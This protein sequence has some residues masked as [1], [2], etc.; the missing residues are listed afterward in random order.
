VFADPDTLFLLSM[1][2]PLACGDLAVVL[3]RLRE[4]WPPPRLIELLASP[5][6]AAAR[7]AATCLGLT[8]SIEHCHHLV[9]LLGHGD[10]EVA[11]AA[12]DALWSIW[13]QAGSD[14]ACAELQAAVE[15]LQD[16]DLAA[17]LSRLD[18]LVASEGSF[19]E[20]RH[21]RA[22][23]LHSLERYEEAAAAYQ[24]ALA[25]NPHHFAAVAGLGHI[26]AER[27]DYA[28]ALRYY[29]RALHIHP[30]LREI[31]ATVPRLEAALRRIVA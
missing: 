28:G 22:L 2:P 6:P 1:D 20:A 19:A 12:E 15:Q 25:L 8:G 23:A 29:Q 9:S 26:C 30:R 31:R 5:L 17:A 27:G 4:G 10:D 24:A 18:A 7:T 13:M 11:A 16:G 14:E 21:Q 3:A